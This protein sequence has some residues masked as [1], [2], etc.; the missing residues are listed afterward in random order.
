M[1][2]YLEKEKLEDLVSN[3]IYIVDFYADWCGPCKMM[4]T[5]LEKMTDVNIIKVNT[6]THQELAVKYGIMSIPTLIFFKDGKEVKKEIGF[7][8][9]AQIREILNNL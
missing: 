6:D 7:H 9:E 1:I 3:G 8:D 4:G 5:V 2:K